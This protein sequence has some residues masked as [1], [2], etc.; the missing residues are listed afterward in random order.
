MAWV[1]WPIILNSF[2]KGGLNIGSLKAFNLALLQKWRWRLLSS[3]NALWVQVIKAYHGQEG[4]FDTN[5]CS[6]K[7]IWAN[8]VGT[9]NFLHSKGIILSNTFRF[10]AGCGTRI[11]FWKDIWVGETPLFT[12]YNRLYHLDQDKDCL[13]IDR[14]NNGQCLEI[15][16]DQSVLGP[17]VPFNVKDA[18]YMNDQNILPT[19]AHATTGIESIRGRMEPMT[20]DLT[21]PS[22]HQLLRSSPGYSGPNMSSDLLASP[23]YLSGLARVSLAEDDLN[24]LIIKYKT[25][26][27]GF[28]QDA[29]GV[30]HRIFDFFG[31]R[32]PFFSFLL[33][34]YQAL[35]GSFHSA[36]SFGF[37]EGYYFK[38]L[39]RSL[40]IEPTMTSF[41]VFQTLYKQGDWFSFA[42]RSD[43]SPVCIDDNRSCMKH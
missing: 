25:F 10:K 36:G 5:G 35:K 8:I 18:R 1:K 34:L 39:Y 19:L 2:D 43:P 20:Q 42:K 29:I 40:Q 11:R 38:V 41:R 27:L 37:E 14:I 6:F 31:V 15:G 28:L 23:E 21:C 9:S 12:R 17:N 33:A 16:L 26:T 22:T 32:I 13:I 4:G 3:P 7:G 30:Y 24:E